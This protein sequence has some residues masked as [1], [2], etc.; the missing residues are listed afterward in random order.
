MRSLTLPIPPSCSPQ[1]HTHTHTHEYYSAIKKYEMLPS[2]ETWIDPETI[3][4][5]EISQT[6]KDK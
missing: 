1:T 5:G 2:A 4:L 3:I 6:E